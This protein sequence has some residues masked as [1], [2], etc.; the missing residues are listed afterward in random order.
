MFNYKIINYMQTKYITVKTISLQVDYGF[1]R[2]RLLELI[3][4]GLCSDNQLRQ[5]VYINFFYT[6]VVDRI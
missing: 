4:T 3:Y 5:Q 2:L 6:K 1:L